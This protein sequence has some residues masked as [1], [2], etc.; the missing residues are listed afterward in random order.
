MCLFARG[1]GFETTLKDHLQLRDSHFDCGKNF[2]IVY[3]RPAV[4]LWHQ[5]RC[6]NQY[7]KS[8]SV[9]SNSQS[10]AHRIEQLLEKAW[11]MFKAKAYV[12]QYTR[13]A[14]FEEENLLNALVFAEQ[15]V[16]NY[17]KI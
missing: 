16:K 9:L 5:P 8:L 17:K 7:E 11:K 15:L 12:H 1:G 2:G 14:N 13:Y 6:F 4:R 3:T 10:P